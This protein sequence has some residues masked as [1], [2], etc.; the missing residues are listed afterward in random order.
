M[1]TRMFVATAA[2]AA[3]TVTPVLAGQRGT[4]T[5]TSSSSSSNDASSQSKSTAA[6]TTKPRYGQDVNIKVDLVITDQTGKE[7]PSRRELSVVV[8]DGVN[9]RVR[10]NYDVIGLGSGIP[11][12]MDAMPEL[13]PNGKI[14]LGFNLQYDG[15][16]Q[17]APDAPPLRGSVQKTSIQQT[18]TLIVESGKP[19]IAAQSAD[20]IGDRRVTVEVTATILK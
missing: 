9:G 2:A 14:R 3:L 17:T 10:S 13:Q 19:I 16:G 8:A 1:L 20:P 7:T 12:N 18:L 5:S 6:P 11:L 15:P 4:T